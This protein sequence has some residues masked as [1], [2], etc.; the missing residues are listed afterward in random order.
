M[1]D[2]VTEEM[3]DAFYEAFINADCDRLAGMIHDDV[4]WSTRGPVAVLRFCGER[5][6]KD[7]ILELSGKTLPEVFSRIHLKRESLV[8]EGDRA[9][10]LNLQ[11]AQ[12]R[13]DGRAITYRF[14]HFFRFK[15]RKIIETATLIDSFNAAEQVLGQVLPLSEREPADAGM[16][17]IL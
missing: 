10:V 12:R 17:V 13:K 1:T 6:G 15:D 16:V 5:R 7:A 3:V 8:I 9:A 11:T 14:A 4:V 2:A